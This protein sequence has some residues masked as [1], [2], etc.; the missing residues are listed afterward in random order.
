M[1]S[2]VIE[3]DVIDINHRRRNRNAVRDVALL[4]PSVEAKAAAL[5]P[6][7]PDTQV[8][9]VSVMLTHAAIELAKATDA[10]SVMEWKAK[11]GAIEE[12]TKQLHLSKALQLDAVEFVRRTERALGL[13]IR[14]GQERGEILSKGKKSPVTGDLKKSS[15]TDFAT[16]SE[17]TGANKPGEGIYAMTDGVSD[18][19]FAEAL[20]E[21]RTEGNLSRANVARK[22]KAKAA[23]TASPPQPPAPVAP[24]AEPKRRL[25]KHDS[26]EMLANISGMLNGIVETLPFVDPADIDYAASKA[27]VQNIRTSMNRI[28]ALLKEIENV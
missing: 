24:V 28:R 3:G 20:A 6:L 2:A 4:P 7:D 16:P 12:L 27:V 23:P 13:L 8:K 22:A 10:Q 15:P 18:D 25:T 26:T 14:E 17:L 9:A 19:Q 11:A 1:T 21:A 5:A